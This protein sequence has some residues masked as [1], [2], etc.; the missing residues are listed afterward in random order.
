[1]PNGTGTNASPFVV[2]W[3]PWQTDPHISLFE[4]D[5]FK[6]ASNN[7]SI[8]ISNSVEQKKHRRSRV[9]NVCKNASTDANLVRCLASS[10]AWTAAASGGQA[11]ASFNGT[12]LMKQFDNLKKKKSQFEEK[13]ATIWRKEIENFYMWVTA[14][15]T[16]R[17]NSRVIREKND[18]EV[19]PFYCVATHHI[20]ITS[21]F[22]KLHTKVAIDREL[23]ILFNPNALDSATTNDRTKTISTYIKRSALASTVNQ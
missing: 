13:E 3:R 10:T 20:D 21:V 4:V 23:Q 8:S 18:M 12:I 11:L 5:P 2:T 9:M 17:P 16:R 7:I 1:V 14:R 15:T 22:A 19:L 6:M